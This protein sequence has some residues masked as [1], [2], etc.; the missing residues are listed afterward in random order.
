MAELARRRWE[1][2]Q[3][4]QEVVENY[5]RVCMIV[6]PQLEEPLRTP[7]PAEFYSN[8]QIDDDSGDEQWSENIHPRERTTCLSYESTLVVVNALVEARCPELRDHFRMLRELD[9]ELVDLVH[10]PLE[11]NLSPNEDL[12]ML[13]NVFPDARQS[14][15]RMEDMIAAT[16]RLR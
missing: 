5:C 2:R 11:E 8:I 16:P 6:A 1:D 12:E 10:A 7:T 4:Q 15:L 9:Q 3:R 13:Q 14:P